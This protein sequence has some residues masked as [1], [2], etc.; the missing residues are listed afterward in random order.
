MTGKIKD[1]F[2]LV[3]KLLF[4]KNGIK[5][6]LHWFSLFTMYV[7]CAWLSI[8][9]SKIHCNWVWLLCRMECYVLL[10]YN[11]IFNNCCV[12]CNPPPLP[13]HT[14]IET[15]AD[16][17][18]RLTNETRFNSWWYVEVELDLTNKA[19]IYKMFQ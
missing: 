3:N 6:I 1:I 7:S 10:H 4:K 5:P 18:V 15:K 13:T 19:I 8:I 17:T 2:F 9:H 12:L 11:S 14:P 16:E